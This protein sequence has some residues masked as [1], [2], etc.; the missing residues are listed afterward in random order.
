MEAAQLAVRREDEDNFVA[1]VTVIGTALRQPQRCSFQWPIQ[2]FCSVT[3]HNFL[4]GSQQAKLII[5]AVTA[6]L[7]HTNVNTLFFI[8]LAEIILF[9]LFLFLII[10]CWGTFSISSFCIYLE[11]FFGDFSLLVRLREQQIPTW[12]SYKLHLPK[13]NILG[14]STRT[15][16]RFCAL[17]SKCLA[18]LDLCP[19]CNV[20]SSQPVILNVTWHEMRG[21]C[22]YCWA[23]TPLIN[24]GAK[25]R[26]PW[27]C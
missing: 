24:G 5:T 2:P 27:R 1:M 8:L 21:C 19:C 11:T 15:T 25:R 3:S 6:G 9:F 23:C 13:K 20:I 7:C 14:L 16:A 26:V 12:G 17:V 4:L 10:F 22:S 18:L